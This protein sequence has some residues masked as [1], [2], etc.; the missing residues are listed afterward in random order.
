MNSSN[1]TT[2]VPT[3][4][5]ARNTLLVAPGLGVVSQF[6]LAAYFLYNARAGLGTKREPFNRMMP[7]SPELADLG[8][9]SCIICGSYHWL[10]FA[11]NFQSV[12]D[13]PDLKLWMYVSYFGSCPIL[14]LEFCYQVGLRYSTSNSVLVLLCLI[15]GRIA[16]TSQSIGAQL[17]LFLLA[18]FFIAWIFAQIGCETRLMWPRFD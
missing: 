2:V 17:A 7:R 16:E 15:I 9:I 11:Y 6:A 12:E 4:D 8:M 18:S 13:V 14:L 5:N 10:Y 3:I 1:S